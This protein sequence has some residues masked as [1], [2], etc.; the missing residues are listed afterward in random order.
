MGFF[1]YRIK[2]FLLFDNIISMSVISLTTGTNNIAIGYNSLLNVVTG[3]DNIALGSLGYSIFSM[4]YI[5]SNT[6]NFTI[7]KNYKL[8]FT[9]S[10]KTIISVKDDL[11]NYCYLESDNFCNREDWRDRQIDKI[12]K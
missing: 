3:M 2:S 9:N 12:I 11:D 10:Q 4:I 8:T 1:I 5:G 6:D 7:G